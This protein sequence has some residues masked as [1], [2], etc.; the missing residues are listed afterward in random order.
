MQE[1]SRKTME[2]ASQNV[3]GPVWPDSQ[4]TP[5]S[6][7]SLSR[8]SWSIRLSLCGMVHASRWIRRSADRDLERDSA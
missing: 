6:T 8:R 3:E 1:M 7:V 4:N 2:I 5:K